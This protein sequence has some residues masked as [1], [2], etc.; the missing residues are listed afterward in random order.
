MLETAG[1]SNTR[2]SPLSRNIPPWTRDLVDCASNY[3]HA[4]RFNPK[5]LEYL[6]MSSQR[7]SRLQLPKKPK[8][9]AYTRK[10]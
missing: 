9:V 7:S 10:H 2:H 3:Q 6:E 5:N 8:V 1:V 4:R